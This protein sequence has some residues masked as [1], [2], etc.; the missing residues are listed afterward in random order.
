MNL[1]MYKTEDLL[2]TAKEEII[3]NRLIFIEDIIAFL[4]C[5]KSTFYEHFPNESDNYKT[6]FDMLETNRTTLKVS[7]RSKWYTS[8]APALQMALMK[9]IATPEEL[10]K[11][12]MN[13]QSYEGQINIPVLTNDPLADTN[14]S[15]NGTKENI[16]T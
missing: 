2:K 16:G 13:V 10:R 7:M 9:L 4:P 1:K 14:E 3:K 12:S 15:D 6:M 8:N 5:H 11:L